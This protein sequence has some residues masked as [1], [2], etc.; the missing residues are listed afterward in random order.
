M[1]LTLK[2]IWYIL[3]QD[4]KSKSYIIF[5]LLLFG[6]FLETLGIGLV[7]PVIS[8]L[9]NKEQLSSNFFEKYNI[10]FL[11]N[12]PYDS[13]VLFTL[14]L[15]LAIY[16]L[17]NV[18]LTFFAKI[19]TKQI[20]DI[21][22]KITQN[23]YK[24]FINNSYLFHLQNNSA[25]LVNYTN[26][27]I[28]LFGNALFGCISLTAEILVTM[29]IVLLLLFFEP[30]GTLI[31][32][33]LCI[34]FAYIFHILVNKKIS[35]LGEQ[36]MKTQSLK[37]KALHE[38]FGA[39]KEIKIYGKENFFLNSFYKRN[40]TVHNIGAS[41][42]FLRR[43]PRLWF[44]F[45]CIFVFVALLIFLII[46]KNYGLI[47]ISPIL[48]LFGIASFRLVPAA[49]R[50]INAIQS[51]NFGKASTNMIF[52]YMESK[53]ETNKYND[54]DFNFAKKIE[55][56]N[57]SFSYPGTNLQTIK[58]I[59]TVINKGDFVGILGTTGSGK[60]SVLNLIL[61][62]VEP[63]EGSI[64]VD[65]VNIEKNLKKW[66]KK[67]GY[68]PQNI[69]LVDDSV[70]QNIAFGLEKDEINK[71]RLEEV[72][73]ESQL[74]NF[75]NSLPSGIETNVGE[76]GTKVSGGEL[77][78]IGIARALYRNPEILIFDEAT[79]SLDDSTELK[80][81]ETIKL[82]KKNKTIF[83]VSHRKLPMKYCNKVYE[84]TKGSLNEI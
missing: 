25:K 79:S 55:L 54:S 76:R 3:D 22:A 80:I 20:F 63:S 59:K 14:L 35:Y 38:G 78:R 26:D 30:V 48:G 44:E 12:L 8:V 6:M 84:L 15:L 52:D 34:L 56:D 74:Y 7:V 10:S 71:N 70:S 60:S 47:N 53:K 41:E 5:V 83:F 66:Q 37:I 17:K 29:G 81:M 62:L 18:F 16:L 57:V 46:H 49:N 24:K 64:R 65:G 9:F 13:L 73:K 82:I 45:L 21:Q 39:I 68:V 42:G 23:L 75:V 27:Q 58:N 32:V 36:N 1:K 69:Y 43:L 2:K 11:E 33:I 50:I 28:S 72:I 61:G 31:I 77:Q 40:R 19:E 4:Q 67:I 51:I